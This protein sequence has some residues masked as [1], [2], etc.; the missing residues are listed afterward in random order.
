MTSIKYEYGKIY[1][2]EPINGDD[3]DVYI[4]STT[5]LLLSQRMASH[6]HEYN[7][8]RKG[9][10]GKTMSHYLFDKYGIENCHIYLLEICPCKSKDE[11]LSRE[12]YYMTAFKNINK[13]IIR[14]KNQSSSPEI[15]SIDIV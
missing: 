7:C 14:E 2:I 15:N 11:L 10:R 4:G 5:K 13:C 6:R 9:K 12:R 8:C 3:G 1:K